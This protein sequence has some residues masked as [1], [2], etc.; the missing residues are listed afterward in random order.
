[1]SVT[2]T[3]T[4]S[5]PPVSHCVSQLVGWLVGLDVVC[6]QRDAPPTDAITTTQSNMQRAMQHRCPPSHSV[7]SMFDTCS[8]HVLHTLSLRW[9]SREQASAGKHTIR[10]GA[11]W[12]QPLFKPLP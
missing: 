7:W 5:P 6:E 4:G 9:T 1:M 10:G 3:S 12:P 8:G 2:D 11:G